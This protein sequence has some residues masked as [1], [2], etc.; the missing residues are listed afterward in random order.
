MENYNVLKKKVADSR[1]DVEGCIRSQ[2]Q[3]AAA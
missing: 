3:Q 1:F 2:L